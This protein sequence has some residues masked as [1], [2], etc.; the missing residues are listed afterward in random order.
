MTFIIV[1][2]KV[3]KISLSLVE[4][5]TDERFFLFAL[6]FLARVVWVRVMSRVVLSP[7]IRVQIAL[8]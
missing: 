7:L 3:K 1:K 8:V 4:R 5:S 6:S 2:N